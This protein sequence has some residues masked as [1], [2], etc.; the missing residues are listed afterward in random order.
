MRWAFESNRISN[1]NT[2]HQTSRGRYETARLVV[3]DVHHISDFW[4]STRWSQSNQHWEAKLWKKTHVNF[5]FSKNNLRNF[6]RNKRNKTSRLTGSIYCELLDDHWKAAIQPGVFQNK[7]PSK[8]TLP[9]QDDSQ[10]QYETG[11]PRFSSESWY[12]ARLRKNRVWMQSEVQIPT[13]NN[14]FYFTI[15]YQLNG[16]TREVV[17]LASLKKSLLA[18]FIYFP[19][20]RSENKLNRQA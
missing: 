13:K 15:K 12:C 17:Q 18:H 8:K 10:E 7:Q 14:Q 20:T 3:P 11:H 5:R 1:F 16:T 2:C 9:T 19:A 4:M 6:A